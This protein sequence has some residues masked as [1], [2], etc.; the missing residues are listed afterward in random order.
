MRRGSQLI[1]VVACVVAAGCGSE[2]RRDAF[3]PTP[4]RPKTVVKQDFSDPKD[5]GWGFAPGQRV[6]N[7]QLV[8]RAGPKSSV[9]SSPTKDRKVDDVSVET[10]VASRD[11]R[12]DEASYGVICR[13]RLA[14]DGHPGDYYAFTIAPNG[15]AAIGTTHEFL[16][17]T[18]SPISAIKQG[19]DAVNTVRAECVGDRLTLYVNDTRVKSL[20]DPR[21]STGDVGVTLENYDKRRTVTARFDD[22]VVQTASNG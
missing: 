15:Y 12:T 22:V 8:L 1:L 21:L 2:Q 6:V 5:P 9:R 13:W 19:R 14:S 20:I 4:E 3:G 16:W 17:Q 10:T 18:A 11:V 7:G